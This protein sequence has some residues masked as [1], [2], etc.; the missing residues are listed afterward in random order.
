[1]HWRWRIVARRRARHTAGSG[2]N[3]IDIVNRTASARPSDLAGRFGKRVVA[4]GL[5]ALPAL[6][7]LQGLSS[8]RHRLAWM[9]MGR[10]LLIR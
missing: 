2:L 5:D 6:T 8:T 1:M 7:P 9:E 3:D 10:C 4:H